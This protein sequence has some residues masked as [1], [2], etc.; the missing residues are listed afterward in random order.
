MTAAGPG[1]LSTESFLDKLRKALGKNGDFPASAKTVSE[2]IELTNRPGTTADAISEVIL[3]EPSLSLRLLSLVNS[4]FYLRGRPVTSLT[5]AIVQVGMKAIAELCA[6]LVLIQKLLPEARK[7]SVF[8]NCFRRSVVTSLLTGAFSAK[9]SGQDQSSKSKETGYLIGFM[10]EIGVLLMTYYFPQVYENA[11]KRSTTKKQPIERS[12]HEIIGLT[13]TQLSIEVLTT[14]GLPPYYKE[15]LGAA[16]RYVLNKRVDIA[17]ERSSTGQTG[18]TLGIAISVSSVLCMEQNPLSALG[19]LRGI[20]ENCKV[21]WS[22]MEA[23]V[24]ELPQLFFEYCESLETSLPALPVDIAAVVSLKNSDADSMHQAEGEIAEIKPDLGSDQNAFDQYLSDLEHAISSGELVTSVITAVMETCAY[25][26]HFDR[27]ILLLASKDKSSLMG[28]MAL[29]TPPTFEVSK[30]VRP[31]TAAQSP[32]TQAFTGG[33]PAFHGDAL[34]SDGW[35]FAFIPIGSGKR[36]IGVIY[37]DRTQSSASELSQAEQSAVALLTSKLDS[38][39]RQ[40][41]RGV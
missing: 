4:S 7:N 25:G 20:A 23:V 13:P 16:E 18:R 12:I 32:E 30:C 38:Y 11:L 2:L 35:P 28:K 1:A 40:N 21:E 3:R 34:L 22:E 24:E 10:S 19:A 9:L 14:L 31:L 37:A 41:S 36:C 6:N 29:G 39:L 8:A 27:V 5:Q 17:L 26:L 15:L 33:F